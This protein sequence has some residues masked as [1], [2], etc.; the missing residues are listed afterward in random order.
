M[1]NMVSPIDIFFQQKK[2]KKMPLM[3]KTGID[4]AGS[5]QTHAN[6]DKNQSEM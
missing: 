4:D 6:T 5:F 1:K 3:L 2:K